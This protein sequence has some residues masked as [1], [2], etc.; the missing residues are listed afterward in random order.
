MTFNDSWSRKKL[1]EADAKSHYY[2]TDALSILRT[3]CAPAEFS[4]L[5]VALRISAPKTYASLTALGPRSTTELVWSRH[6]LTPL[7]LEFELEWASVWLSGHAARLNVFRALSM[8]IQ[9][10]VIANDLLPALTALDSFVAKYGW[11]LW[12]VELRAALLQLLEGTDS[13]RAW[14]SELQSSTVNSI[15]GL[16]FQMFGD[17]ND[18]TFSYEA[19]YRKCMSSLPR[20]EKIAPWLVDY[21]KFRA[22]ANVDDALKALPNVL[23]RDI[24]SSLID[25]YEDVVEVLTC[26][27][28]DAALEAL[29][30]KALR[31]ISNLRAKGFRDHRLEKLG[32]AIS[33]TFSDTQVGA[34]PPEAFRALYAASTIF[35]HSQLPPNVSNALNQCQNEGA[36]AHEVVGELLKWGLNLRSLDI[37][38]AVAMSAIKA[39][40]NFHE[41]RVLPLSI[42]LLTGNLVIDDAAALGPKAAKAL[43][44]KFLH[45]RGVE[46]N[47]EMELPF[48]SAEAQGNLQPNSQLQLVAALE[49]LDAKRYGELARLTSM[50]SAHG[51]YWERQCAKLDALSFISAGNV[52]QAVN[53][54]EEWLRKDKRYAREF[55]SDVF[56]EANPWTRLR[57][58]NVVI[59]GIVAHYE[60]EANGN[61]NVGYICKMACRAFLQSGLRYRVTEDFEKA[62]EVRKT[63]LITF[64]RDVWIEENLSMCHQFE[65]TLEVREERMEVIQLLLGWDEPRALEYS[66]AIRQITLSQTLQRGLER[67]DQTRVFVNESAISRWAEKE[68][69][70]DYDR[71]RRLS[72]SSSGSRAVDDLLRQY[73]LD[74]SNV[75]LLTELTSGKPTVS[76]VV[77]LDILDRLYKRFLLDPTEGLD[78]Y[79]SV[80][81]RHG[82]LRGTI[83]GP[84]EEQGLLFSAEFSGDAFDMRWSEQLGLTLLERSILEPLI[85][86][87]STDVH[88]I[89]EEFI[90]ERI[91]VQSDDKP[92]GAF[93]SL[94]VAQAAKIIVLALAERPLS[95]GAL[96]NVAYGIFW[97]IVEAQL[98]SLRDEVSGR[99]A[100]EI[101][102]RAEALITE[103]RGLDSTFLPL[104]T[105]LTTASTTTKS[106]CDT[107]ADWFRLPSYADGESY[108]L[109][110]AISIASAATRN[111]HRSF[112]AEIET[113]CLPVD[114]LPLTT[115]ALSVLMDC[116]FVVFENAWKHSGLLGELPAIALTAEYDSKNRLLM[117][118]AVS[119]VSPSRKTELLA[120]ELSRLRIKYLGE[121]PLELVRKEGG[122]GFPKLARLSR[123]VPTE[124][125]PTPFDFGVE[126]DSWF[127]QVTVPLY[128]RDGA[129][130]AYDD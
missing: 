22:L 114:A 113:T 5:L 8:E 102:A 87:F 60:F 54:L 52:T 16:L 129:F 118:R 57:N 96:L 7:N 33:G 46:L 24:S 72:E 74:P 107:V 81:I 83:L 80:R 49:L 98:N 94:V 116:L 93:P 68:L 125:C 6:A 115:S 64:L 69:E 9:A 111:V 105:T 78:A 31:V 29:R 106:Q 11:S 38:P 77:L 15:P 75:A 61:A 89:V 71:W 4:S 90:D 55:P 25:Y 23:S 70:G 10:L 20:F 30:P 119:A 97:Q 13:Q 26:V 17:R 109:R 101:R 110:D 82:S 127:T 123:L 124:I 43:L 63:Q 84:L 66:E 3:R 130:D 47:I 39:T 67:I 2:G 95:F 65:S 120:G 112:I 1:R 40:S 14:L 59:V 45:Q 42:S 37:G 85:H 56:F 27:E 117:L 73:V 108:E 50:L 86:G 18:D 58:L 48:A 36:A 12:A 41:E 32:H 62:S 44:Q 121:L 104:I 92:N 51:P 21:L 79:L 122:S 53:L 126:G 35:E 34:E 99:I 76:D 103:L 100:S 28:C 128:K 91:Q 88:R 19:V